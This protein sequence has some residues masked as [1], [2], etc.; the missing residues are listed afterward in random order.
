MLPP[1]THLEIGPYLD[2]RLCLILFNNLNRQTDN[3]NQTDGK[4][5]GKVEKRSE[6]VPTVFS[7]VWVWFTQGCECK[8][9]GFNVFLI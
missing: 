4:T 2:V 7:K 8:S 3:D 6:A 1:D 9:Q 5:G